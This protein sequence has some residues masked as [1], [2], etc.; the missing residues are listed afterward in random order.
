M[1]TPWRGLPLAAT[2]VLG[3]C[4]LV[5]GPG[6]G[7]VQS[8]SCAQFL[9]GGACDEQARL[10][11][12]RHPGATQV[13]LTCTSPVCDRKG[14]SGTA[15]ITLGNGAKVTEAFVYAGNA[16]PI[17]APACAGLAPAVCRKAADSVVDGMPPSKAVLSI[18]VTCS[19]AAC[20][21]ARGDVEV[22]IRL[23]D[24]SEQTSSFGWE[25]GLP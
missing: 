19:V 10:V 8:T 3:G 18:T 11:A 5:G 1:R 25:G 23:A 6:A 16:A 14:G 4:G 20:T 2:I 12:S 21:E 24:G 7:S 9:S 22:S 17:P 13:D 15:V